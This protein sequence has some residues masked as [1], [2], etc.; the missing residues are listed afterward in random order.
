MKTA[1]RVLELL[2]DRGE[3]FFPA[4]ELAS[5]A[6]LTAFWPRATTDRKSTRLNSSH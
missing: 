1:D 5:A 6:G 3:K 4:Q 2:F